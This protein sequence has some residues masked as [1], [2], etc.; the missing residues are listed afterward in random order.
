M[1]S[2]MTHGQI[3]A[4]YELGRQIFEGNKSKDD[5]VAELVDNH[6]MSERGANHVQL[7]FIKL[8]EGRGCSHDIPVDCLKY[9]FEKIFMDFGAEQIGRCLDGLQDYL[10]NRKGISPDRR[11]DCHLI[12]NKFS[13]I[14]GRTQNF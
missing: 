6:G 9:Y 12:H 3:Q 2:R 14:I 5:T 4:S 1:V 10:T 11:G 7:G 8:I 13:Q